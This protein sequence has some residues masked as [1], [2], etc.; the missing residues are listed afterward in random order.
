MPGRIPGKR[1][2]PRNV[3]A[4]ANDF[5]AEMRGLDALRGNVTD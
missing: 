5:L 4:L 2:G 3:P 1:A